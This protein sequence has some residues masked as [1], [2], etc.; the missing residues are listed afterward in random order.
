V[1]AS[2]TRTLINAQKGHNTF[3]ATITPFDPKTDG[4]FATATQATKDILYK[5]FLDQMPDSKLDSSTSS[6]T[7]DGLQFDQYHIT[8]TLKQKTFDMVLLSKLYKGYDFGIT[9]LYLD[10]TSKKKIDAILASS[11]FQQ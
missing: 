2:T 10:E 11:Q 7:I 4:D 6:V 8:V 9:Y 5:T 3:N 1:D